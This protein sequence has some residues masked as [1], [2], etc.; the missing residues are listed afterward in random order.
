[1]LSKNIKKLQYISDIHLEYRNSYPIIP[2]VGD[3]LALNG[4]IGSP[5]KSSYHDFLRHCSDTYERTFLISGNHE[6]WNN[7][8]IPMNI[9]DQMIR[10]ITSK[11]K[12]VHYLNKDVVK[13]D[14]YNIIGATLWSNIINKNNTMGDD[15]YIYNDSN[16]NMTIDDY[17]NIHNDHVS[18]ICKNIKSDNKTIVLTHHLPTYELIHPFYRKGG[19]TKYQDRFASDLD[20]IIDYPIK[21]WLCGH[22]HSQYSVKIN[23]VFCGINAVGKKREKYYDGIGKYVV[24]E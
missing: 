13:V 20:E 8:N 10:D 11:F 22:S 21:A 24:L 3:Y 16:I 15:L 6:Y 23:N 9:I 4:D 7:D 5:F 1:M 17:K 12:N 19:Y 2:K 14:D 18:W